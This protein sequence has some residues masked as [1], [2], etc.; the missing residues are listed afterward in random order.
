M[1]FDTL[2]NVSNGQR[3]SRYHRADFI[4]GSSSDGGSSVSSPVLSRSVPEY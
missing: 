3:L 2:A 4:K 1:L